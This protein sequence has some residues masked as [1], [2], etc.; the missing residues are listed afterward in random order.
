MQDLTQTEMVQ[1]KEWI[2]RNNTPSTE[3]FYETDLIENRIIDSLQFVEFILFLES[4][5]GKEIYTKNF[6][7][8]SIR[9]LQA[10][11]SNYFKKEDLHG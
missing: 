3:L 10:I 5:T 1:I 6:N 7:L 2:L 9:S 4:I 8:E 11:E